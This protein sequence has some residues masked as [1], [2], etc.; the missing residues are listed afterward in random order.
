MRPTWLLIGPISAA[1]LLQRR[2]FARRL[3]VAVL[4]CV[5]TFGTLLP[6]GLR[7]LAVSGHFTFTTFWV[8]PSLYDGLNP[9]AN[10]DSD[11][12][13]FDAENLLGRMS[14]YEMDR[15]YRRRA[16]EFAAAHPSRALVLM[17]VKLGRYWSI[18]PNAAQFQQRSVRIVVAASFLLLL[19]PAL[20][21]TWLSRRRLDVLVV[22]WGPILYF[23]AVHTL[24]V[25]SIRYRLPAE[26]PFAVLFAIG[27]TA[28][29]RGCGTSY[30]R[31]PAVS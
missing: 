16:W 20:Y 26:Y 11:M 30:R 10:G 4:I 1:L 28:L 25:G 21:G 19:I 24:F 13:F 8:G 22:G 7:N 31:S 17:A 15:E 23:A 29:L 6:W 3:R 14:E 9:Q 12:T 5:G 27:A 2:D 18:W